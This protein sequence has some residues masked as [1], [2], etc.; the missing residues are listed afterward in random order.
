MVKHVFTIES[1]CSMRITITISEIVH[2]HAM[3]TIL[4]RCHQ[5]ITYYTRT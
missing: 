4:C 3:R 2:V 1:T 5:M